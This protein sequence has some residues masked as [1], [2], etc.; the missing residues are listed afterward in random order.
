MRPWPATLHTHAADRQPESGVQSKRPTGSPHLCP[1]TQRKALSPLPTPQRS[2]DLDT[3]W[4]YRDNHS[5]NRSSRTPNSGCVPETWVSLGKSQLSLPQFSHH[6]NGEKKK[7]NMESW[8]RAGRCVW[9]G[10]MDGWMN[11]VRERLSD[12]TTI[13]TAISKPQEGPSL[14]EGSK[15]DG[16]LCALLN[17]CFLGEVLSPPRGDTFYRL[18]SWRSQRPRNLPNATQL[19]GWRQG[20]NPGSLPGPA[21]VVGGRQGPGDSP[22]ASA[23]FGRRRDPGQ[24]PLPSSA[25]LHPRE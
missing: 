22:S 21:E 20:P 13:I 2:E 10:W 11:G 15:G 5:F 19:P 14:L 12:R 25:P 17:H 16:F 7:L 3:K 1:R 9:D 18:E 8:H 24:A 4:E 6:Q 23:G